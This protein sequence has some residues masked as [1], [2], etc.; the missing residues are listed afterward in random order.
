MK[1]KVVK[2]RKENGSLVYKD[3]EECKK[4]GRTFK[5]SENVWLWFEIL[6][7]TYKLNLP[8]SW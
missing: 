7:F 1:I 5:A 8:L 4:A 3:L 6:K 2:E